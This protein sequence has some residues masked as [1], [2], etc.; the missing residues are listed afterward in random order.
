MF[1]VSCHTAGSDEYTCP[2][3]SR[4]PI[5][6]APITS[7]APPD[8]ASPTSAARFESETRPAPRW[9][10]TR[11]RVAVTMPNMKLVRRKKTSRIELCVATSIGPSITAKPAMSWS[12]HSSSTPPMSAGSDCSR[13]NTRSRARENAA[14]VHPDHVETWARDHPKT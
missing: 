5:N 11:M 7:P 10:A 8:T 9:R 1:A 3:L 12:C 14:R 2:I 13:R 6:R 4:S